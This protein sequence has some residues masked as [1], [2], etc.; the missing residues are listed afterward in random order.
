MGYK[1]KLVIAWIFNV[2]GITDR[3]FEKINKKY[4]NNYIRI[5]NYHNTYKNDIESFRRQLKWYNKMFSNINY[6]QFEDFI[7]NGK[8]PSNK[9]GIMLTFDDGKKGN[10]DF[11]RQLLQEFGFTGYFMCSTDLVGTDGYMTYD[12]IKQL[13]EEGNVIADHTATHHRMCE[14]DTDDI[15]EY[16][17]LESKKFLEKNIGDKVDIFCWCGGEEKHYTKKAFD[18]IMESGYKYGFMTNCAPVLKG[19]NPFLIQRIN[20]ESNWKLYLVKFQ[21]S[22]YMDL[23]FKAKRKRINNRLVN[24]RV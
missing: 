24:I 9:P 4:N 3:K 12:E 22:G 19:E 1:I 23:R 5:L 13:K 18:K 17:I 15:L 6:S 16:E 11:A 20:V 21:V 14:N 2:L 10:Y 7:Q 8:L